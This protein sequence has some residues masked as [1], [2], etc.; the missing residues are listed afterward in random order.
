[1]TGRLL[2]GDRPNAPH[3][4]PIK[5]LKDLCDGVGLAA[6]ISFYCPDE[7][8]WSQ[9][10]VSYLPTVSESLHNLMLVYNF[11]ERSLPFSVFHMMPEDVTYMRG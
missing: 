2:Q 8:P 5:D 1:M 4:P 10:L 7:L 3:L 9:L 6:L 11:C